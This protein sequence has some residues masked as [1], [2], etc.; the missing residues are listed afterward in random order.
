[1]ALFSK[2]HGWSW[3]QEPCRLGR[4]SS[5]EVKRLELPLGPTCAYSE[6]LTIF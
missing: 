3:E 4:W 5:G 6:E 1:M 2:E